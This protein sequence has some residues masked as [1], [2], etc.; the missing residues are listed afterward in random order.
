MRS[1]GVVVLV[2]S[3]VLL[4]APGAVAAA[5]PDADALAARGLRVDWPLEEAIA[6]LW[7]GTTLV[8]RVT[9]TRSSARPV[10][11]SLIRVTVAGT[12][13]RTIASR[14]LRRGRFAVKVPDGAGRRYELR[15]AV[16]TLRYRAAVRTSSQPPFDVNPCSATGPTRAELRLSTSGPVAPGATVGYTLT[17]TGATCLQYAN[18]YGWERRADDG[19]WQTW[20]WHVMF[21][22]TV[23]SLRPGQVE[24][25]TAKV[26][27]DAAPGR[28]RLVQEVRGRPGPGRKGPRLTA[29]AE[30]DVAG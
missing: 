18:G 25:G 3:A 10:R 16:G 5:G 9:P 29:V 21:P 19:T 15:L 2:S 11:L 17:D 12:P 7:P 24:H 20:P 22:A 13:M 1:R 14:R 28:F 27:P 23:K 30:I 26:P 4:L 8:V 6:T